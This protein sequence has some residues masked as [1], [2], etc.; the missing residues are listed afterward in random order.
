MPMRWSSTGL[1]PMTST[2]LGVE[3]TS[4]SGD[5][6]KSRIWTQPISHVRASANQRPYHASQIDQSYPIFIPLGVSGG[7]SI[8]VAARPRWH[9]AVDGLLVLGSCSSPVSSGGTKN[10][11]FHRSKPPSAHRNRGQCRAYAQEEDGCLPGGRFGVLVLRFTGPGWRELYLPFHL[12]GGA[13][14]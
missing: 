13:S 14:G 7:G 2:W 3:M 6:Q 8:P 4:I 12:S 5:D 1:E 10:W 9:N 11:C